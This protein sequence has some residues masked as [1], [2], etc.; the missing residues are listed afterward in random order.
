MTNSI[1]DE[2]WWLDALAP[3][4]WDAVEV[5]SDGHVVALLPYVRRVR[6]GIVSLVQPQLTQSL[7]PWIAPSVGKYSSRL[8]LEKDRMTALLDALPPFHVFRQSFSPAITNWLPFYWNGFRSSVRYTY[9]LEDLSDPE[10]IWSEFA[11][12]ARGDVRKAEK[13]VEVRDDLP[14]ET[15]LELHAATYARQG[16]PVPVSDALLRRL[17]AAASEHGARTLLSAVDADEHVRAAIYVVHDSRCAYYL[18][19]GRHLD[20]QRG[21]EPALLVWEA[22]KRA[23]D[24]SAVFDFEGSMIESIE[25]FFRSFGARQVPYFRIEATRGRGRA[26]DVLGSIRR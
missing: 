17:D 8:Q 24:T 5:E 15:F 9:R 19:S 21:G 22:I 6:R 11:T 18:L 23:R 14:F 4:G 7:G 10:R 1:F 20:F 13:Q 26:Y 25:R 3:G 2:P 16:M 12:N